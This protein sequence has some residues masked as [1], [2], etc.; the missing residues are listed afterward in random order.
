MAATYDWASFLQHGPTIIGL[1]AY[2]GLFEE[3]EG[4]N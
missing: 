4:T 2:K 3:M 1:E